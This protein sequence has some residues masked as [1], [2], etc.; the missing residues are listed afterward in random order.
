MTSAVDIIA[1]KPAARPEPAAKA[2][3]RDDDRATF[4]DVL[5]A[6]TSEPEVAS[7]A[8]EVAKEAA[9]KETVTKDESTTPDT[10]VAAQPAQPQQPQPT[11]AVNSAEA[12]LAGL[13]QTA[14]TD[15]PTTEA[16]TATPAIDAAAPAAPAAAAPAG[17]AETS[18]AAA[19]TAAQAA[20]KPATAP[21]PTAPQ[22]DAAAEPTAQ[23][24]APAA[25][26]ATAPSAPAQ[27]AQAAP[28]TA[29]DTAAPLSAP[30]EERTSA[31]V[32]AAN[33]S[34]NKTAATS[35]TST[36]ADPAASK[37]Q[38]T[39]SK[40][41]QVAAN[42]AA[43]ATPD[44]KPDAAPPATT[45]TVDPLATARSATETARA[46]Q[47]S[48]ALQNA[49]ATT[50]QVYQRMVERFDGRAQRYEVRLDPAELGRV[51][52]RI[53]VGADKKVH[54]VLAAHDSAALS[55]L[56][57]GQRSLERALNDA[58]FDLAEGGIRFELSSDQGR[59]P[60]NDSNGNGR[61]NVWRGFNTVDVA[62]DAQ[63]AAAARPWRSSAR[64]DV[65]A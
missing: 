22:A 58:G 41:A 29:A 9:P 28:P 31:T 52:V 10:N 47:T 43:E 53:E 13:T 64:L 30:G 44:I 35:A 51:D 56:M 5:D 57:R 2:S 33:T 40:T 8:K 27:T 55:D 34:S 42:V 37:A 4:A 49:P 59:N 46:A 15:A 60:A 26:P 36:A 16:G 20:P 18:A 3:S 6:E 63:T 14:P 50:I 62:V 7:A 38:G 11:P 23:A 65:V 61:S 48:P 32:E 17:A 12:I 24:I 1:P 45:T 25:T 21:Q 19:A 39:Q 54:A